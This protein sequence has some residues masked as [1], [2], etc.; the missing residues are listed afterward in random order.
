VTL[1]QSGVFKGGFS[2]SFQQPTLLLSE[3]KEF[4]LQFSKYFFSPWN[5]PLTLTYNSKVATQLKATLCN[6]FSIFLAK[7]P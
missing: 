4:L 1:V 6:S 3:Q 7:N 2:G 5:V